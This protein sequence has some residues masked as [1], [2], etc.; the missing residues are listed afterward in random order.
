MNIAILSRNPA[1]YSTQSL[2]KAARRRQHY[3]RV[4]DYVNCDIIIEKDNLQISYHNEIIKNIDAV[5]PRIGA[6]HT[7]YGAAII[8]QFEMNKVYSTLGSEALQKARNKLSCLQLLAGAG[9][10][11]PKSIMSN[12]YMEFT[13]LIDKLGMPL[14]IKL[15][16]GTHG[17]G[18]ILAEKKMMAESIFETFYKTKQKAMLQE[19]IKEADGADIR[20]FVVGEEVVGVMQRKAKEGDFRSNL[21]RGASSMVVPISDEEREAAIKATKILDLEIAGVDLLRSSRGPLILEVNASPGLEG[22][23]TT[24]GVDIAG[25]IVS[26][27]ESNVV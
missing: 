16:N 9:L 12:N 25:K 5:I 8:R 6:S 21:H 27:I 2:V 4:L 19:F 11:V 22:I 17:L 24:T 23:E 18:V 7:S 20:I 10:G 13:R 14:I 15:L 26:F 3:V 1:L